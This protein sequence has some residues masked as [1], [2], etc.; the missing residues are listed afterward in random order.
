MDHESINCEKCA[1]CGEIVDFDNWDIRICNHSKK[2]IRICDH[3]ICHHFSPK[4]RDDHG[5]PINKVSAIVQL[6]RCHGQT[7]R[8]TLIK[9]MICSMPDPSSVTEQQLI[10]IFDI[11][12]KVVVELKKHKNQ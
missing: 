5:S 9:D 8:F 11:A 6:S 3:C 1:Y 7:L 2:E 4:K 10:R 12:N